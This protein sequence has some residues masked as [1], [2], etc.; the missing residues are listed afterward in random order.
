MPTEVVSATWTRS[1]A[2]P[3]G[4]SPCFFAVA[5]GVGSP[6]FAVLFAVAPGV[7][8]LLLFAGAPGVGSPLLFA[9]AP[10]TGAPLLFAVAPGVGAL[11][12]SPFSG[13][14]LKEAPQPAREL[15]PASRRSA[16]RACRA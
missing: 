15:A 14:L 10:G 6:L 11:E 4:V 12:R 3:A 8:S 16:I 13:P 1:A 2:V 7:G 9:V 5:P